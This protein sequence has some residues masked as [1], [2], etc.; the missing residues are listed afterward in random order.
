MLKRPRLSLSYIR[1]FRSISH[2]PISPRSILIL[3]SQ[4]RLDLHSVVFPSC[5]HCQWICFID[6]PYVVCANSNVH[7]PL[8]TSFQ[9]I[10]LSLG[11]CQTFR[12]KQLYDEELLAE[13]STP[14]AGGATI[15][16]CPLLLIQYICSYPPYLQAVASIP[17]LRTPH[18]MVK[19]QTQAP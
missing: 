11:P 2:H 18:A 16:G 15:V 12:K 7:F 14:H 6:I 5:Y 10:I 9:R 3:S 8:L 13:G 1:S 4:L 19:R 17:S